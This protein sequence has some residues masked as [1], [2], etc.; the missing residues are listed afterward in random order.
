MIPIKRILIVDDEEC[1]TRVL[2]DFFETEGFEVFQAADGRGALKLARKGRFD[3][4]LTDLNMPGQDGLEVLRQ[5]RHIS[6]QTAVLIF[7]GYS[8]PDSTAKAWN[9]RTTD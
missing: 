9:L 3:V 8:C 2:R 6:P 1:I 5:I 4:V 7:S